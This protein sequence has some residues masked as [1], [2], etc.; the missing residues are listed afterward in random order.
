MPRLT[1][2]T[3]LV[4]GGA[5]QLGGACKTGPYG[6]TVG[7]NLSWGGSEEPDN[8]MAKA[9]VSRGCDAGASLCVGGGA[10][11]LMARDGDRPEWERRI[12]C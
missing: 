2:P 9:R 7:G 8:P 11:I 5:S 12:P 4:I 6:R 10:G 1:R 3:P